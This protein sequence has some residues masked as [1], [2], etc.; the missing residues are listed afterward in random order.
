MSIRVMVKCLKLFKRLITH[1]AIKNV[2][3]AMIMRCSSRKIIV[4]NPL[5][6]PD[7]ITMDVNLKHDTHNSNIQIS[8]SINTKNRKTTTSFMIHLNRTRTCTVIF[9]VQNSSVNTMNLDNKKMKI[10]TEKL[11]LINNV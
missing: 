7:I 1:Y 2:K 10:I 6:K 3:I 11:L 9:M 4:A 5:N 8:N